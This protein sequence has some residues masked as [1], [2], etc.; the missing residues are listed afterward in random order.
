MSRKRGGRTI[1]SNQRTEMS[2][3]PKF[4]IGDRVTV[5]RVRYTVRGLNGK[6][7]RVIA[8]I[9]DWQVRVWFDSLG[10]WEGIHPNNLMFTSVIDRLA[11]VIDD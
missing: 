10:R 11:R 7:G 1:G 6:K 8:V 4:K 2:A 5:L 9:E 3:L